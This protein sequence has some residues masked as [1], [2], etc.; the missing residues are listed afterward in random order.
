MPKGK[1]LNQLNF[2][3]VGTSNSTNLPLK[4][5]KLNG[6]TFQMLTELM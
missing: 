2:P 3:A 4:S 5:C 1:R 6:D